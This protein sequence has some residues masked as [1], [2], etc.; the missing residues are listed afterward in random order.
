MTNKQNISD[1]LFL[2]LNSTML[3]YVWISSQ[4]PCMCEKQWN[5]P[6]V[7]KCLTWRVFTKF[8]NA[9]FPGLTRR[10]NGRHS[11]CV[12]GGKGAQVQLELTVHYVESCKLWSLP[13]LGVYYLSCIHD[14]KYNNSLTKMKEWWNKVLSD[15]RSNVKF[16]LLFT[17]IHKRNCEENLAIYQ[18][19]LGKVY[20]EALMLRTWTIKEAALSW[21]DNS[22]CL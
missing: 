12:C 9:P 22:F 1:S 21:K 6:R 10:T 18:N 19:H 16:F 3:S 20:V 8:T 13:S 17:S 15:S 2:L 7:C 5:G 14:V 4:K 11:V